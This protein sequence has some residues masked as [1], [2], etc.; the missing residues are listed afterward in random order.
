MSSQVS[1][2]R[3]R[4]AGLGAPPMF[5]ALGRLLCS[6]LVCLMISSGLAGGMAPP[7]RAQTPAKTI[8]PDGFVA[9]W[10][11]DA[12]GYHPAIYL[13]LVNAGQADLS[14]KPIKFQAHF[15][16]IKNGYVTVARKQMQRDFLPGQ[17]IY[18]LLE[19]PTPFELPIDKNMWPQ[20]ECHVMCR[21]GA[22]DDDGNTQDVILTNIEQTAMT[23]D[24]A[25]AKIQ[26]YS[27]PHMISR[28]PAHRPDHGEPPARPLVAEALPLV[29]TGSHG[30]PASLAAISSDH[31]KGT[32]SQYLSSPHAIGLGDDFYDFEQVFGKPVE[33]GYN[34]ETKWTWAHYSTVDSHLSIFAGA[35]LHTSKVD[36]LLVVIPAD[37]VP[38][39]AQLMSLARS[40]SGKFKSQPL[41]GPSKT[42]KYLNVGRILLATASAPSYKVF[43]TSPRGTSPDENNYVLGMSRIPGDFRAVFAENSR[44]VSMLR[45]LSPIFADEEA[46]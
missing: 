19:G 24:E 32:L 28:K 34:H 45:F 8:L 38:Q 3:E 16:D 7:V 44:R 2:D 46:D 27:H 21:V 1:I 12:T 30:K 18:V 9:F 26:D 39:D 42:V 20:I 40:L 43:Y 36:S 29:A 33:S 14:W 35:R 5:N 13:I 10:M 17:Q 15:R 22:S 37:Q 41:S 25:I 11:H 4:A 6:M 23:D 31:H